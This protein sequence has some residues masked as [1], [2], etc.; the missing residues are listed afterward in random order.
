MFLPDF[1]IYQK[2]IT[3][4]GFFSKIMVLSF[5]IFTTLPVFSLLR[6]RFWN[7]NGGKTWEIPMGCITYVYLVTAG[8]LLLCHLVS[9]L[10]FVTLSR[11]FRGCME[12]ACY[13]E[14]CTMPTTYYVFDRKASDFC[15]SC[16]VMRGATVLKT[17]LVENPNFCCVCQ[18]IVAKLCTSK[19]WWCAHV[20]RFFS[21]AKTGTFNQIF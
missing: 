18:W 4:H 3:G 19:I 14:M 21:L 6:S 15:Q 7:K 17:L 20:G 12:S 10:L 1:S 2:L 8:C 16:A 5:S 9:L 11:L 13:I